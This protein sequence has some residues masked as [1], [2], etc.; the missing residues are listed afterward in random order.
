MKSLG[1]LSVADLRRVIALKEQIELL[2]GQLEAIA[3]EAGVCATRPTEISHAHFR[4][5]GKIRARVA[6][7]VRRS[8]RSFSDQKSVLSF[9]DMLPPS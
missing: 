1:K 6:Q 8:T 3:G 4:A 2:E 7:F 5:A 9:S